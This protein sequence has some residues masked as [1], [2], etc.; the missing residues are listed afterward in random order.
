[1]ADYIRRA[2][3]RQAVIESWAW[4]LDALS[5]H[6]QY[7]HPHQR[8]LFLAIRQ[9]SHNQKPFDLDYDLLQAD[10]DYLITDQFS[11]WTHIYQPEA[12]RANFIEL[13]EIGT[14]RLY[15]RIR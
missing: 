10:P 4:E 3:P 15:Q 13:A 7:H 11:S 5:S 1:M 12:I 14:Y 6:W 9:F 2:I 8:Y